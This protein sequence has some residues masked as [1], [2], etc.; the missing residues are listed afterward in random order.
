VPRSLMVKRQGEA[1]EVVLE[2]MGP[3]EGGKRM[4]FLRIGGETAKVEVTFPEDGAPPEYTILHHGRRHRVEFVEIL[5]PGRKSMPVILREDDHMEE[6]L[7][8]FPKRA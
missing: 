5:N 3:L 6:I 1:Y 8:S 4:L 7:F 2:G